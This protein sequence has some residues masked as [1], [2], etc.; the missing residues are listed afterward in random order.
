MRVVSRGFSVFAVMPLVLGTL[1][2][3]AGAAQ[4]DLS[5]GALVYRATIS[6]SQPPVLFP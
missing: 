1:A 5:A 2:G 4:V 6:P 3:P